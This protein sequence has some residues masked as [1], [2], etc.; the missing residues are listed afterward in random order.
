M[1]MLYYK[2]ISCIILWGIAAIR[3]YKQ[4]NNEDYIGKSIRMGILDIIVKI[5]ILGFIYYIL[6]HMKE[7]ISPYTKLIIMGFLLTLLYVNYYPWFIIVPFA[8]YVTC[9]MGLLRNIVFYGLAG[10]FT[11]YGLS[12]E[13]YRSKIEYQW[14]KNYYIAVSVCLMTI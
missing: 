11:F 9:D 6:I 14:L 7:A 5:I 8:V 12:Q 2:L 1:E 3:F 10:L 13:P 4:L